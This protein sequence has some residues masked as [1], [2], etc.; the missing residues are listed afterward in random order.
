MAAALPACLASRFQ[1]TYRQGI[2]TP[3]SDALSTSE[4]PDLSRVE[5]TQNI[6]INVMLIK[7]CVER[8]RQPTLGRM[9]LIERL[10]LDPGITAAGRLAKTVS[11]SRDQVYSLCSLS[12]F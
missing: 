7:Y 3:G 2:Q 12:L 9:N 4:D 5:L 11:P 6:Y 10:V 8:M 1:I